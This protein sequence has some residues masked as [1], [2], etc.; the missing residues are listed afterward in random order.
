MYVLTSYQVTVLT[1]YLLMH[2]MGEWPLPTICALM[3][4]HIG[5]LTMHYYIH[6]RSMVTAHYVCADV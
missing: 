1:K 3:C 5:F 4:D 6:H 2:T